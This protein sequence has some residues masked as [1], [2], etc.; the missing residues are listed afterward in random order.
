[1]M[2][3]KKDKMKL[4]YGIL[5]VYLICCLWL[6]YFVFNI[7]KVNDAEKN[8]AI[9]FLRVCTVLLS[10]LSLA[11]IS[12]KMINKE[13]ELKD[14][15]LF[16]IALVVLLAVAMFLVTNNP[17]YILMEIMIICTLAKLR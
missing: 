12:Y 10:V 16:F 3:G 8:E 2:Y 15:L 5:S 6:I 1:M 17:I 7:E 13:F 4:T 11:C 9:D 14:L